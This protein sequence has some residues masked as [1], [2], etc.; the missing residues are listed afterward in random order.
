MVVALR[1]ALHSKNQECAQP[2][3]GEMLPCYGR[4]LTIMHI[5]THTHTLIIIMFMV[6]ICL[7][8]FSWIYQKKK[9]K[10]KSKI[11][12]HNLLT[13]PKKDLK[14]IIPNAKI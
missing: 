11:L 10:V 7:S 13:S 8:T 14:M 2:R 5:K 4:T 9:S 12:N 3:D 6:T 1:D